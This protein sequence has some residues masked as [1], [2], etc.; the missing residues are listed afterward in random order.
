MYFTK[1]PHR[2]NF[3]FVSRYDSTTDTISAGERQFEVSV[4][5]YEGDI[6][7]VQVRSAKVW[8]D[9][10][11]LESLNVPGTSSKHHVKVGN[12]FKL[13]VLG[14]GGKVLLKG[15]FGVSGAASMFVFD[16]E[17]ETHFF[18]MGEKK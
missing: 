1:F 8:G 5:G 6:T 15:T 14:K 11:C 7:H 17:K 18:G 10:K 16:L 2:S 12:D 4:I 3:S 13:T 9:N